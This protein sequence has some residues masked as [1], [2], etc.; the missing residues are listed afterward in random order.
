MVLPVWPPPDHLWIGR[1][2]RQFLPSQRSTNARASIP[3]DILALGPSCVSLTP[4]LKREWSLWSE[5]GWIP[6]TPCDLSKGYFAATFLSSS[7]IT[8]AT[9]SGLYQPTCLRDVSGQTINLRLPR[10]CE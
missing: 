3:A 10:A 4:Q 7:P 9:Q 1:K 5:F 8:P 2:S 6:G